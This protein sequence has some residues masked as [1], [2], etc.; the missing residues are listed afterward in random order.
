MVDCKT[1]EKSIW[2]NKWKES[3]I[4]TATTENHYPCYKAKCIV[5]TVSIATHSQRE[6]FLRKH[7]FLINKEIKDARLG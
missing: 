1:Y 5:Q 7:E 2:V 3:I 6:I 4:T